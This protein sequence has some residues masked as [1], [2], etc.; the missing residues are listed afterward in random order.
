MRFP[1]ERPG[2]LAESVRVD[3]DQAL[4]AALA[5]HHHKAASP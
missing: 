2:G 4:E 5:A 1:S 3:A